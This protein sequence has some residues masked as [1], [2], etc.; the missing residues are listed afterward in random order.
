LTSLGWEKDC[1]SME[2]F[3]FS[4]KIFEM[5]IHYTL[6]VFYYLNALNSENYSICLLIDF[7][8]TAEIPSPISQKHLKTHLF[9]FFC[10]LLKKYGLYGC[11]VD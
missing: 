2:N 8:P 10:S 5:I 1:S 7:N 6:L 4:R 3:S 11:E 9:L